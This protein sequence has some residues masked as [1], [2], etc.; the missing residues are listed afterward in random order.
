MDHQ[1]EARPWRA[2]AHSDTQSDVWC[3]HQGVSAEQLLVLLWDHG[4]DNRG[5][6][7]RALYR[8]GA[9]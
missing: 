4:V 6:V 1:R 5:V 9:T 3:C 8:H 2:M 7:S